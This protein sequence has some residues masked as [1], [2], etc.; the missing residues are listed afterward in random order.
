MLRPAVHRRLSVAKL[1]GVSDPIAVL[2]IVGK[3]LCDEN[4]LLNKNLIEVCT[5]RSVQYI[6]PK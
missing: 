2:T 4:E 3:V 6:I 5:F 1:E